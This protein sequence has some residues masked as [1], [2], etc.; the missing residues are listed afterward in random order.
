MVTGNISL[1]G[2]LTAK[3]AGNKFEAQGYNKGRGEKTRGTVIHFRWAVWSPCRLTCSH[4]AV[5]VPAEEETGQSLGQPLV[6]HW[7]AVN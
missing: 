3:R 1:L 5:R 7:T 4:N 6:C 2:P